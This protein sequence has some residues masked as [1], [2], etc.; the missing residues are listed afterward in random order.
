MIN[1]PQRPSNHRTGG[2]GH[3]HPVPAVC[4]DEWMGSV[5]ND[6]VD[7]FCAVGGQMINYEGNK[8]TGLG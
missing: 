5:E 2:T 6:A 1:D 3:D 7:Q 4:G 8:I